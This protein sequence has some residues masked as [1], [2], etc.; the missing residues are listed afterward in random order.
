MEG[1][2]ENYQENE[3]AVEALDVYGGRE[4]QIEG[5]GMDIDSI[6]KRFIKQFQFTN[7]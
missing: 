4:K 6:V 1:K 5:N 3:I 7:Y 2:G